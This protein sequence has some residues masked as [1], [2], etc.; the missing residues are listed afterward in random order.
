MPLNVSNEAEVNLLGILI[1]AWGT[2]NVRL[3]KSNTTLDD[4]T[5][6]GDFT[7]ADYADAETVNPTWG[8]PVTDG[9]GRAYTLSSTVSFP[10]AGSSTQVVYGWYATTSGG[11]YLFGLRFGSP[12]TVSTTVKPDDFAIK[13]T[14]RQEP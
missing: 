5:V 9:D 4:D 8:S 11:D 13:F 1:G 2:L 3:F 14:L 6:I 12:V 7:P 10:V